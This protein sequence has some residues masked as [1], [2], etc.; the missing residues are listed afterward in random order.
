MAY[1]TIPKVR[2]DGSIVLREQGGTSL[3]VAFEEGNFS[4]DVPKDDQTVIRD[5][6]TIVTVRRG[7]EQPITGS[8]SFFFRD[9]TDNEAGSVRDFINKE[10]FYSG[11]TSTG[12]TG[13]PFVEFYAID[14]DFEVDGTLD[15]NTSAN[16]KLTLSKAVCTFSLSEGDPGSYTINFTAYGGVSYTAGS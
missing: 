1:S 5:R 9:F 16:P 3:Q 6:S 15:G 13:T 4:V 2:R 11:N 10:N 8:F 12:S 7:D 14:I